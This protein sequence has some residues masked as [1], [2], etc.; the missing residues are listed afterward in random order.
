MST[1]TAVETTSRLDLGQQFP[2][3]AK[4][5]GALERTVRE[6]S[7]DGRLLHLVKLRASMLNGCAYCIDMHWKDAR[8][9]GEEEQRL[10]GLWTWAEV[11]YYTE[12]ER[13][14]FALTDAITRVAETHVPD[15]VWA[16]AR[17]EF[18]EPELAEL[19]VAISTINTWNR[20]AI[21]TRMAPGSYQPS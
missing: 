13:A 10:Y 15:D 5:M 21:A 16:E 8:L 7:I 17:R 2:A 12:R 1:T 14:A 18:A 20:I 6:S 9:A 3:G 4:A 19:V 11:P